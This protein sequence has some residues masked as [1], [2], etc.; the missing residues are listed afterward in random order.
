MEDRAMLTQERAV[1]LG[2]GKQ[3]DRDP[4][5]FQPSFS[6]DDKMG[7]NSFVLEILAIHIIQ[8]YYIIY[9]N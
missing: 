3:E 4:R 5:L 1:N 7:T 6:V 8:N 2:S 9:Y